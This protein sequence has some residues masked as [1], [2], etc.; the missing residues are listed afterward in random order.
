MLDI[1]L[2]LLLYDALV[3]LEMCYCIL[4]PYFNF[5]LP[6]PTCLRLKVLVAVLF[7]LLLAYML[8]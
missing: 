3:H 7:Q 8:I 4:L 6:V 1:C 5:C 2:F